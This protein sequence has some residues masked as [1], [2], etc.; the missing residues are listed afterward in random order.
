MGAENA[1]KSSGAWPRHG[2]GGGLWP[3]AAAGGMGVVCGAAGGGT[4]VDG[5]IA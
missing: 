2:A 1:A 3:L 5:R 4:G